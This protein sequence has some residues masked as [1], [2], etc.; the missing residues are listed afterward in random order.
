MKSL[1]SICFYK[2]STFA[3]IDAVENLKQNNIENDNNTQ[4]SSKI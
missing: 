2:V 3:K 4:E 1:Y